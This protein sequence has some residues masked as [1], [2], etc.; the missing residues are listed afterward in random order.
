MKYTG[1]IIGTLFLLANSLIWINHQ[2]I[3][4]HDTQIGPFE[5]VFSSLFVVIGWWLGKIYDR[6][7]LQNK[8]IK[9]NN[10]RPFVYKDQ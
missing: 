6:S 1:R 8:I 3:F 2:V 5:I 4:H 10:K 9:M 7:K